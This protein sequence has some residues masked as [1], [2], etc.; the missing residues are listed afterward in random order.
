MLIFQRLHSLVKINKINIQMPFL[1]YNRSLKVSITNQ[2][3]D[4]I[5]SDTLSLPSIC[6]ATRKMRVKYFH[7]S[8]E[9]QVKM[10]QKF[11]EHLS[12]KSHRNVK[13]R[14]IPSN[15]IL[16]SRCRVEKKISKRTLMILFQTSRQTGLR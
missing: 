9:C 15:Y 2:K 16:I 13:I 7:H 4:S 6:M 8:S 3:V 14:K 11:R 10:I 1:G 5:K 12:C